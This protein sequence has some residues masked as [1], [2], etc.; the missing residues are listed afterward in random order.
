MNKKKITPRAAILSEV[1]LLNE[2][3]TG[4][5]SDSTLKTNVTALPPALDKI[6][7]LR[8]VAWHWKDG[9]VDGV[10]LDFG[11]IA[12]EVEEVLPD[13]VYIDLWSDGSERK[14][15]ATKNMIPYLVGAIQELKAEV[16]DLKAK[17]DEAVE[18]KP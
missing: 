2:M 7:A 11:F 13:L 9:A 10:S 14:F 18:R 17:L 15:L 12:Q 1:I 16:D 8:L 4:G 3:P 5:G 6:T